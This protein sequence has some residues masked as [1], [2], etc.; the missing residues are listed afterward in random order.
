MSRVYEMLLMR[1]AEGMA[2]RCLEYAQDVGMSP[3]ELLITQALASRLLQRTLCPGDVREVI[4][5]M[6][7]A[8]ATFA[9]MSTPLEEN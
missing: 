7:I 6:Q 3:E 4:D 5:L 8:D 1:R 2:S 9:V